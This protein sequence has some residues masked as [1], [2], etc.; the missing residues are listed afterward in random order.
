MDYQSGHPCEPKSYQ[1]REY[2]VLTERCFTDKREPKI[3]TCFLQDFY[4]LFSFFLD[5]AAVD[6]G[7]MTHERCIPL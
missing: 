2:G 6:S 4:C 3:K 5:D 7:T 1:E